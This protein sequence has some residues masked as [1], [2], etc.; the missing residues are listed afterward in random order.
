MEFIVQGK[1][2]G[3][4]DF[5]PKNDTCV[6]ITHPYSLLGGSMHDHVVVELYE[7]FKTRI[8]TC[9]FQSRFSFTARQEVD[10]LQAIKEYVSKEF[11]ITKFVY[12]GYS[13]GSVISC[14]AASGDDDVVGPN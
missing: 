2:K 13:F 5:K 6:I 9:R 10:D 1:L 8:N 7:F 4:I 12:C 11:G 14:A 3:I